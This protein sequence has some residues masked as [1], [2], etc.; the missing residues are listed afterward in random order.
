M[1]E[2]K[3]VERIRAALTALLPT[4]DRMATEFDQTRLLVVEVQAKL[5]EA[6]SELVQ[7]GRCFVVV[8]ETDHKIIGKT[9][10]HD[11]AATMSFTPP[12]DPQIEDIVQ[13]HIRK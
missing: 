3:E 1:R 4:V 13:V 9:H 7:A 12:F 11:I 2:P 10:N 8:L 5:S 6:S